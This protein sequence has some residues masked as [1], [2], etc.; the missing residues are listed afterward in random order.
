[1][2][3][4]Y[5]PITPTLRYKEVLIDGKIE[6]EFQ[7]YKRPW[8]FGYLGSKRWI[9]VITTNDFCLG[10]DFSNTIKC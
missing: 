2:A 3:T 9:W 4:T 5:F 7:V 10:M 8:F 1:M 6:Y